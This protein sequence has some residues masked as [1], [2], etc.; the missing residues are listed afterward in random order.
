MM[1]SNSGSAHTIL[2]ATQFHG[3]VEWQLSRSCHRWLATIPAGY[4]FQPVA[5]EEVAAELARVATGDP[6]GRAPDFGGPEVLPMK[7]LAR[8]YMTAR[9]REAPV[10]LYPTAGSA[11]AGYRRG[12][13]TN[14]ERAVGSKTWASFLEER[15]DS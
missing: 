8:S 11:A 2:R 13:H 3:F 12:L 6:E 1:I 15:F 9:G 14:P 10:L 5:V 4:V 7:A